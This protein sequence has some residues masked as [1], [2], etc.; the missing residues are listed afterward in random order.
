MEEQVG[1]YHAVHGAML[2]NDVHVPAQLVADAEGV[3]EL[4]HQLFLLLGELVGVGGVYRGEI[5]VWHRI[6]LTVDVHRAFL[7]VYAVQKVAALHFPF[8][9]RGDECMFQLHLHHED[10]LVHLRYQTA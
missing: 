8:R 1:V 10:S 7:A 9:V 2:E 3:G 5:E 4:F 6:V